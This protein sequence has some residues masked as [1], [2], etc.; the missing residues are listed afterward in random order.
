[1]RLKGVND[2]G[3]F[4]N[5]PWL[6]EAKWRKKIGGQIW[7]WILTAAAK[8]RWNESHWRLPGNTLPWVIVMAQDKRKKPHVDLAV[9]PAWHYFDLLQRLKEADLLADLEA[10]VNYPRPY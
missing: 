7:D 3:D 10:E 6:I 5:V 9:V 1:M 4:I 2:Y 8:V